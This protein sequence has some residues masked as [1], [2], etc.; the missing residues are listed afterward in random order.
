MLD[1]ELVFEITPDPHL[2]HDVAIGGVQGR[3][4]GLDKKTRNYGGLVSGDGHS[5]RDG[6][7]YVVPW[8]HIKA[9]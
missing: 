8:P 3:R 4:N 5:A 6:T 1:A 7:T 9:L 2:T